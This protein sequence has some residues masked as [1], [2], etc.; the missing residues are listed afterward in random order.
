MMQVKFYDN[1]EDSLLRFAVI[2]SQYKGRWVYCKH[3]NRDTY[4][5]PGG[6]REENE[7]IVDAAKRE[8]YEETGAI[9]YEIKPVT[10]YSVTDNEKETFGMLYYA[11]IYQF[12]TE[13]HCEIERVEMF[14][15]MPRDLTYPLI[16]PLLMKEYLQRKS[17]MGKYDVILF[18]LDGTL[19][20]SAEGITNSVIF[21]LDKMG[22]K[23]TDK[24]KLKAFVGPPLDESFMK[25]YGFD[26][27]GAKGAIENY[28]IYYREKGIFE[29]PLYANV[30]DILV[31]LK[32]M[33]KKLFVATSK[34]EV[35]AK[36]ILERWEIVHLFIDI[37]GSNLDGS[38]INKDEVITSLLERNGIINKER[39]LMVGDRKH[40]VLGAKMVGIASVG[41]L[42][43]YGDYDELKNAGADYI[44][45]KIEDILNI[46]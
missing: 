10:V 13:L 33:G 38:K 27:E 32:N 36:Q 34:P 12:E 44:V 1:V 45:E 17:A 35:F 23:E 37:V 7:T 18:D 20:E 42:Y 4:E 46:I 39:V 24:E 15:D 26:K 25:Y 40:D 43:G 6:H 22:V 28:R 11:D 14:E 9:E 31:Q 16:Q 8:L 21:A 19:T 3:K 41:V 30:K 2:L 29:A 5:I